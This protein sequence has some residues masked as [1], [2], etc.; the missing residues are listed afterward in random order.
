MYFLGEKGLPFGLILVTK[1][2][3]LSSIVE[4]V[5]PVPLRLLPQ[6]YIDTL[7]HFLVVLQIVPIGLVYVIVAKQNLRQ[8]LIAF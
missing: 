4:K 8:F 5:L 6:L 1:G 3:N 7:E 2:G